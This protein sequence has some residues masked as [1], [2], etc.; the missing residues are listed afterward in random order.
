MFLAVIRLI[1]PERAALWLGHEMDRDL[2]M[3][4][5]IG[6]GEDALGRWSGSVS[7]P[8]GSESADLERL[9]GC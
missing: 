9:L 7:S 3:W 5:L 8:H 2:A 1:D 6:G 4:D